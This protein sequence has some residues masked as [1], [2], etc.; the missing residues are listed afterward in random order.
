MAPVVLLCSSDFR[1]FAGGVLARAG[2][3]VALAVVGDAWACARRH[4]DGVASHPHETIS[5]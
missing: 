4:G 3:R 2:Q 5:G 1:T